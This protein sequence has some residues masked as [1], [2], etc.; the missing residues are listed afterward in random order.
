MG[1]D[2]TKV[3]PSPPV[4]SPGQEGRD[5][6]GAS[7]TIDE[8]AN[9]VRDGFRNVLREQSLQAQDMRTLRGEM[10]EMRSSTDQRF[11]RIESHLWGSTPPPPPP[12]PPAVVRARAPSLTENVKD[13]DA[14]IDELTGHVLALM[15]I[16]KTQSKAMGLSMPEA[17]KVSKVGRFLRSRQGVTLISTVVAAIV[18]IVNVLR[19]PPPEA[20]PAPAPSTVAAPRLSP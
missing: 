18:S 11:E 4:V 8:L 2:A 10:Q 5:E 7:I 13:A 20:P 9:L 3:S 12:P 1:D 16:A 19:H 6:R 15:S 17:S 14:R